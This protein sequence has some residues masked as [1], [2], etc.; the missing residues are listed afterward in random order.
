MEAEVSDRKDPQ[1]ASE[2]PLLFVG[3]VGGFDDFKVNGSERGNNAIPSG[4]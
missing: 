4:R 2:K 1:E 3:V